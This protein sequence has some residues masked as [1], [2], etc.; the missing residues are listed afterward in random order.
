MQ[1]LCKCSF[2]KGKRILPFFFIFV[3]LIPNLVNAREYTQDYNNPLTRSI[4]NSIYCLRTGDCTLGDLTVFG[5][6]TVVGELFNATMTVVNYVVTGG[7]D[8]QGDMTIGGDLD[9]NGNVT[10][11]NFIGNL[12]GNFTGN[13]SGSDDYYNKSEVDT[14]GNWTN[15]R[16][17]YINIT[18]LDNSTIIRVGNESW[19]NETGLILN[20]SNIISSGDVDGGVANSVYLPIQLVDGGA[21]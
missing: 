19:I 8:V 5:N 12:E 2:N 6:F 14:L 17:N 4:A 9:V 15:D 1:E 11:D 18:S 13:W 10:A 3:L 16:H 21:A 7:F 20:W